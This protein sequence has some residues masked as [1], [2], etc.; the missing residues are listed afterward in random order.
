MGK[1][2]ELGTELVTE[3]ARVG[4]GISTRC[5]GISSL[6]DINLPVNV[7]SVARDKK[8]SSTTHH[9]SSTSS[10]IVALAFGLGSSNDFK[11]CLHSLDK[12]WHRNPL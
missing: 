10:F 9:S 11:T 5:K 6:V 2:G 8:T 4:D 1:S 3:F 12:S 7:L